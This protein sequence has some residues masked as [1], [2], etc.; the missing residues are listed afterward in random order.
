MRACSIFMMTL[1]LLPEVTSAQAPRETE[2]AVVAA[3]QFVR[4]TMSALRG[5]SAE[6]I[7]VQR[8]MVVQPRPI[9][10][11]TDPRSA[12]GA[13]LTGSGFV[14]ADDSV[15]RC[16]TG[17]Q[18]HVAAVARASC[19]LVRAPL[20]FEIGRPTF[21]GDTAQTRIDVYFKTAPGSIS[22]PVSFVYNTIFLRKVGG[23]WRAEALRLVTTP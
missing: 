8:A 16:G 19:S 3:I 11:D 13:G 10:L 23:I 14:L 5:I 21:A 4:A 22:Y 20:Y 2:Q 17:S 1:A 18:G 15:A 9:V 7:V 12:L 6:S